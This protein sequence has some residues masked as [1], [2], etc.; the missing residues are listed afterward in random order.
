M[1]TKKRIALIA[2]ILVVALLV[3]PFFVILCLPK[4]AGRGIPYILYFV[5]CAIVSVALGI[6]AGKDIKNLFYTPIILS[7]LF[8]FCFAIVTGN[9]VWRMFLYSLLY[10]ICT[11]VIMICAHFYTKHKEENK[12]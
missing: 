1:S 6:I 5:I 4:D 3:I 10:L 8:P 9:M 2:A 7:V 11:S 12:K